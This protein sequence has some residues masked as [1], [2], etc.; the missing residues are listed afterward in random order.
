MLSPTVVVPVAHMLPKPWVAAVASGL[1]FS[2]P[3]PTIPFWLLLPGWAAL[4]AGHA[5]LDAVEGQAE[6]AVSGDF[7]HPELSGVAGGS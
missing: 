2:T 4:A 1:G 5:G 3:F 7:G 6:I